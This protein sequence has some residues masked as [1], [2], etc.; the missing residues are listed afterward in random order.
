LA[1]LA[2]RARTGDLDFAHDVWPLLLAE[3]T[4]RYY[5][6][7]FGA[8]AEAAIEALMAPSE[9]QNGQAG[10]ADG[11]AG[12]LV[13]RW[14]EIEDAALDACLRDRGASGGGLS[15]VL[16]ENLLFRAYVL[17]EV[18]GGTGARGWALA[19]CESARLGLG[20]SPLRRALD[21]TFRSLRPRLQSLIDGFGL[22]PS[23][24]QDFRDHYFGRISRLVNGSSIDAF[25]R[26]M[27]VWDAGLVAVIGPGEG[28]ADADPPPGDRRFVPARIATPDMQ[29][30]PSLIGHLVRRGVLRQF[31]RRTADGTDYTYPGVWV[32]P[33]H[34]AVRPDGSPHPAVI[35]LGPATEGQY[36]FQFSAARPGQGNNVLENVRLAVELVVNDLE[37]RAVS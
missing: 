19:N 18:A 13:P 3:C 35:V 15:E 30:R 21:F 24:D 29:E 25:D 14:R 32:G 27:A 9:E 16:S 37:K 22:R 17:G 8:A 12:D 31:R 7:V 4:A 5:A 10:A 2:A 1:R 20:G 11:L 36:T 26:L 28:V 6:E 33:G 34:R 23:S